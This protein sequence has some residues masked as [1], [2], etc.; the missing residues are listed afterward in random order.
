[1][2]ADAVYAAEVE[3][4]TRREAVLVGPVGVSI[5]DIE[6]CYEGREEQAAFSPMRAAWY[7]K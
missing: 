1:M 6:A 2:C 5:E 7:A 3:E 4:R